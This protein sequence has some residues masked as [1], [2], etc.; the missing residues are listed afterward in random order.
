MM[1]RSAQGWPPVFDAGRASWARALPKPTAKP[2]LRMPPG[3]SVVAVLSIV[4]SGAIAA[5]WGGS[6]DATNNWLI[7]P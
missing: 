7:A 1:R 3:Y 2:V 5:R 6:V 4:E